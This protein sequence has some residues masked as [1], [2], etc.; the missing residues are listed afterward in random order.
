[1]RTSV[2]EFRVRI[3]EDEMT[4]TDAVDQFK[5]NFFSQFN[6]QQEV[7]SVMGAMSDKGIENV[8]VG[9]KF[10]PDSELE[11]YNGGVPTSYMQSRSSE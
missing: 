10:T 9:L 4:F 2:T 11:K 3:S 6:S 1:M 8:W 7:H 5:E